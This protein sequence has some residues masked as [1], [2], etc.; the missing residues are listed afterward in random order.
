MSPPKD[1][2]V[3]K[4]EEMHN[5]KISLHFCCELKDHDCCGSNILTQLSNELS[6]KLLIVHQLQKIFLNWECDCPTIVSC[7]WFI[8][9]CFQFKDF[10]FN[11]CTDVVNE[12]KQVKYYGC[13]NSCLHFNANNAPFLNSTLC[14]TIAV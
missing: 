13:Q 12:S 3:V 7:S 5:C 8:L 4:A 1:L 11:L 2:H 14:L 9:V 10:F 6:E